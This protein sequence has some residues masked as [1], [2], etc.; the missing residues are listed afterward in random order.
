MSSLQRH[1]RSRPIAFQRDE[2]QEEWVQIYGVQRTWPL[3]RGPRTRDTKN[4]LYPVLRGSWRVHF[5]TVA[6]SPLSQRHVVDFPKTPITVDDYP[7]PR[8][9]WSSRSRCSIEYL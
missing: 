9:S 2:L 3:G 4:R 6:V 1:R 8:N 5:V 7:L